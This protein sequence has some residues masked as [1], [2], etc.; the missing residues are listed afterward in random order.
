MPA[1]AGDG[2]GAAPL[3][4]R[5]L[6]PHDSH[7]VAALHPGFTRREA[8]LHPHDSFTVTSLFGAGEVEIGD[9]R[10]AAQVVVYASAE[11]TLA[12]AV[13]D[14]KEGKSLESGRVHLSLDG[15]E[16]GGEA[17]AP[18]V[19]LEERLGPAFA[20]R[21]QLDLNVRL[22]DGRVGHGHELDL[23]QRQADGLGFD[24]PVPFL[25]RSNDE[26]P[27]AAL[28]DEDLYARL[29]R[30]GPGLGPG[31]SCLARSPRRPLGRIGV[32]L[33]AEGILRPSSRP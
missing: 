16:G 4:G 15:V 10:V 17:V 30:H 18:E 24:D 33:I 21:R 29:Y 5:L 12:G 11:N 25:G 20:P 8:S 13:E 1:I 14:L 2:I 32:A 9:G 26:A 31:A 27:L 28:A 19:E 7:A 22:C 23:G 6:H 3:V